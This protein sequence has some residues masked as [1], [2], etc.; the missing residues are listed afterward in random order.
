[1]GEDGSSLTCPACGATQLKRCQ[2][3]FAARSGGPGGKSLGG[4]GCPPT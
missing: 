2:S 1:M 3:T 4:G